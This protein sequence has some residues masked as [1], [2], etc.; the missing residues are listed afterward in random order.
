MRKYLRN[1]M[2]VKSEKEKSKPSKMIAHL[3]DRYQRKKF[4]DDLR[5]KHQE[6]GTHK[7]TTWNGRVGMFKQRSEV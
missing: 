5:N 1:L 4:G 7:I 6:R 2:R 3:W